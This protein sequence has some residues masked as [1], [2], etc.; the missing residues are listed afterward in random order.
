LFSNAFCVLS[1][2]LSSLS[3]HQDVETSTP[4]FYI[5]KGRAL[6]FSEGTAPLLDVLTFVEPVMFAPWNVS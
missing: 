1:L 5:S 2:L 6:C 4:E 3:S